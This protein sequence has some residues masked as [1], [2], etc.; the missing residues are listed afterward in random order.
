L[1]GEQALSIDLNGT[2]FTQE[3]SKGSRT[4]VV[5]KLKAGKGDRIELRVR[6]A[7]VWVPASAG[8]SGD[9]RKLSY[10]LLATII[11]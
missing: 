7:R 10:R 3:L 2:R 8:D 11:E 9:Q 5:L 4:P 1:E 6:A